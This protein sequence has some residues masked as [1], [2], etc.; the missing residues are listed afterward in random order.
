[1]KYPHPGLQALILISPAGLA[2]HPPLENQ[3]PSTELSTSIRLLDVMWSSNFTPQQVVRFLGPKGPQAVKNVVQRRFGIDR[4]Q[5]SDTT[6]IAD[7]LYHITA[8][9]ASGEY[10]VNSLLKPIVSK[11]GIGE[12]EEEEEKQSTAVYA[13]EPISPALFHQ[14]ITIAPPSSATTGASQSSSPPVSLSKVPL[15]PRRSSPPPVLLLYGDHDWLRF[16][17]MDQ[18]VSALRSHEVKADLITIPS[19]GHH[20][21]L[22]NTPVFHQQINRWLDSVGIK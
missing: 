3:I 2:D 9:P 20:L 5:E 10:A 8:A 21:Y 19:A 1:M 17:K 15:P 14:T 12:K 6:L 18:Y 22:D 4:W 11:G 16:P 13:R 7:Y